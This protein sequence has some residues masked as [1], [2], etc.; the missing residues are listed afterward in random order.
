MVLAP[1]TKPSGKFR[2]NRL[3]GAGEENGQ[4]GTYLCEL[5]AQPGSPEGRPHTTAGSKPKPIIGRPR[6]VRPSSPRLV[7]QSSHLVPRPV[8]L[9]NPNLSA[10]ASL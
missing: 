6:G 5:K 3:L 10:N 1:G 9:V 7:R 2:R 4:N 8:S